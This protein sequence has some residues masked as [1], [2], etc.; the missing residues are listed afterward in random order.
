MFDG[1]LAETPG[2]G[3]SSRLILFVLF[4]Y[5]MLIPFHFLFVSWGRLASGRPLGMRA[6]PAAGRTDQDDLYR[7]SPRC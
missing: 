6:H 1:G 5:L 2:W 4:F 7:P 3:P